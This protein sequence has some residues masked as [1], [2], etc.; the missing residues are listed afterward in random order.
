MEEKEVIL[1]KEG[2]E[3]LEQELN[4]K[5]MWQL[6]HIFL[7]WWTRRKSNPLPSQCE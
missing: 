7:F 1:T 3:K 6:P 4:Y 2:F 5:K